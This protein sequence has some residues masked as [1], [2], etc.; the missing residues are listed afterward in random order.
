[1]NA[2]KSSI[3]N[4]LSNHKTF[5]GLT[6][7]GTITSIYIY[8][9]NLKSGQ[10]ALGATLAGSFVGLLAMLWASLPIAIIRDNIS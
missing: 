2:A 6:I 1:M 4:I 5:T 3:N 9:N 10:C 7:I 8:R